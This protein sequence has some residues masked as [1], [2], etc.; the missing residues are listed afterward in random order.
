ML[1][2]LDNLDIESSA[3]ILLSEADA[4]VEKSARNIPDVK[5][6]RTSCLNVVDILS[7]DT[8]VLPVNS[9]AVIEQILG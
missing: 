1:T 3:L 5:T 2:V 7:Y 6:L 8:L 9:I 4:N